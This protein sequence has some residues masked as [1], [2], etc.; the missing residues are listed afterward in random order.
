MELYVI[1]FLN[2]FASVTDVAWK[3]PLT[4]NYKIFLNLFV[5]FPI[6]VLG[7]ILISKAYIYLIQKFN[8]HAMLQAILTDYIYLHV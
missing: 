8:E 6:N 2:L 5:S 3:M 4:S 7:L 1:M